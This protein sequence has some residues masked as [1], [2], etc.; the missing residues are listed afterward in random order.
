MV[1][2]LKETDDKIESMSRESYILAK[3]KYDVN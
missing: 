1:K 2:L 3:K